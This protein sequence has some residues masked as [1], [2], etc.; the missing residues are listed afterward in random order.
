MKFW[1]SHLSMEDFH[2]CG[3][4]EIIPLLVNFIRMLWGLMK[5]C[6]ENILSSSEKSAM[7]LSLLHFSTSCWVRSQGKSRF[8]E[9]QQ[10]NQINL[11]C[12]GSTFFTSAPRVQNLV[13]LK[14]PQTYKLL[15]TYRLNFGYRSAIQLGVMSKCIDLPFL[16]ENIV[17]YQVLTIGVL[18][19]WIKICSL[20]LK[21]TDMS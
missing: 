20:C 17:L 4:I 15:E 18:G 8:C 14:L 2:S 9:Y 6:L 1:I 13:N 10:W 3:K 11:P 21:R 5:R 12:S 7:V 16:G 19:S